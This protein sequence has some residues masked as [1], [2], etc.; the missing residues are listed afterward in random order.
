MV[1]PFSPARAR[2]AYGCRG[3]TLLEVLTTVSIMGILLG[4]AVP[5]MHVF[6]QKNRMTSHINTFVSH[7]HYGRSEAVKRA[8]NIVICRSADR[9][10]CSGTSGWQTGWIIFADG[11]HNRER[12][13]DEVILAEEQGWKDGIT[14][15]SGRR[16][17]VVFQPSGFSPGTNGTYVFCDPAYPDTARAVILSNTGRPRLSNNRPDGSSLN[18]GS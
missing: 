10:N 14:V 15:T 6:V 5:A 2:P 16:R 8:S 18:C 13:D 11:N 4:T 12:D 7:L 17:R 1:T 3:F 9:Q